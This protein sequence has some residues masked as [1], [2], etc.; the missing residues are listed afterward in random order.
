MVASINNTPLILVPNGVRLYTPSGLLNKEIWDHAL[1]LFPLPSKL[2]LGKR[3]TI[4][5]AGS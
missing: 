3:M 4:G 1:S 5:N 2:W